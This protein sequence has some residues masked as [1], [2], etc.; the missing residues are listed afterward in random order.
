MHL[1]GAGTGLI[2]RR[3]EGSGR[4]SG[5][6]RMYPI[7]LEFPYV[8]REPG[9][10]LASNVRGHVEP[11]TVVF[12]SSAIRGGL[13]FHELRHTFAT[14][15]LESCALGTHE[16]SR[17]MGHASK[18]SRTRFTPTCDCATSPCTAP[19]Y[20]LTSQPRVFRWHP[21]PSSAAREKSASDQACN[22]SQAAASRRA[23]EE[24]CH[25]RRQRA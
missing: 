8:Y 20:R 4:N 10:S 22:V 14:L 16:L 11:F 25:T 13:H 17:A 18:R 12:D 1:G 2:P 15:A 23:L 19:R 5:H 9:G 3:P 7:T 6:C 24:C 21:S